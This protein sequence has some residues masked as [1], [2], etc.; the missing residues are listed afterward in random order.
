M[1]GE[2]GGY[3]TRARLE[4]LP[5]L[6][7]RCDNVLDVGCGSGATVEAIRVHRDVAWAGGIEI[8][9]AAAAAARG[10]LDYLYEGDVASAPLEEVLGPGSLDL[11]LCLDVLEHLVDPWST[12]HRLTPLLA[13][14]GRLVVS[15]PNIRNWKFIWRLLTKG[16]FRYRDSGL[17]DRTH[18]RFFVR[19]TAAELACCGGLKLVACDNATR[20]RASEM[21][22]WISRATGGRADT[23]LAKQFIVVATPQ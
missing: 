3:F 6:P 7:Q 1:D 9:P 13:P 14:G 16:D 21:R 23:L 5:Y 8:D 2:P 19:E 11:V 18:L 10:H 4:V 20:Y 15:V 22:A 12:V 17:L